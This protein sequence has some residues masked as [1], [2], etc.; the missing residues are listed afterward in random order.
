MREL[1]DPSILERETAA[2]SRTIYVTQVT[3]SVSC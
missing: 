2:F 1:A 3:T